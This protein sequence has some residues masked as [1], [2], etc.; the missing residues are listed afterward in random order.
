VRTCGSTSILPCGKALHA[1]WDEQIVNHRLMELG[2]VLGLVTL[3]L[4]TSAGYF[5]LDDW[6]GGKYRR[7]SESPPPH[8]SP[9][10]ASS[11]ASCLFMA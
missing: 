2:G 7:G 4:A 5:R 8:C 10:G 9:L 6:T 1:S 3:V 11:P